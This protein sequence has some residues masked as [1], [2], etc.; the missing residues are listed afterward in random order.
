MNFKNDLLAIYAAAIHAVEGG[1]SVEQ[2]FPNL[3]SQQR[4]KPQEAVSVI[5]IGKAADAMLQ[6]L[7]SITEIQ[8]KDAILITKHGHIGDASDQNSRIQCIEADHP[9]P[10][11][12]SLRAGRALLSYVK[13]LSNLDAC[14]VLISGG[15]SSL[16]EVLN[17]RWE[18]SELQ[19]L[20]QWMMANSYSIDEMNA[21]RSRVSLI[22]SGG[23]WR[24][25][26][27]HQVH[28]LL[29]SDVPSDDER[30]IGSG[31]LFPADPFIIIPESLP[32]RW[33]QK[34]GV[35]HDVSVPSTFSSHIIASNKQAQQAA[36]EKARKLGYKVITGDGIEESDAV[37]LAKQCVKTVCNNSGTLFIWGAETTVSLPDFAGKGG[38]NQHLSLAAAIAIDQQK[39]RNIVLLAAATDGTDGETEDAGGMVDRGT[40]VRGEMEGLNAEVCLKQADSGRFLQASGDLVSTGVTGTNVMDIII[41]YAEE[42]E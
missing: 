3:L 13:K 26:K 14:I 8:V 33:K 12:A 21:V 27:N 31:L 6:G 23:L 35:K 20:T 25:L 30:V 10:R 24:Y 29:I 38:R 22:K 2:Y 41:A 28:C 18:L 37:Y 34:L 40:I 42:D 1:R 19:E 36:A 5:A 7:L 11:E 4:I 16:V 9:V 39:N 17:E 15:T 32:F